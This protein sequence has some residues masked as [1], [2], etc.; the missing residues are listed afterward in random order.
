MAS[1]KGASYEALPKLAGFFLVPAAAIIE[2]IPGTMFHVVGVPA[3]LVL[4]SLA[5]Y[6]TVGY[7]IDWY[8]EPMR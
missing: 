7:T 4:A 1:L 5:M 3:Y 8:Y 2:Y 6:M